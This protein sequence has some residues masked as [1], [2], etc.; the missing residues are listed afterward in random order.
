M[1]EIPEILPIEIPERN[2]MLYLPLSLDKLDE[3]QYIDFFR[4]MFQLENQ[5]LEYHEFAIL[6]IYKLLG[7]KKGKRKIDNNEVDNAL[8]NIARLAEFVEHFFQ[9]EDNRLSLKLSYSQNHI[10]KIRLPFGK[11]L[12][13]PT[14]YFKEV[15]FGQYEDGL[16]RFL[17]YNETPSIELLAELAATFYIDRK[18]KLDFNERKRKLASADVGILFGFYYTFAA[19]HTYFSGSSVYYN[20]KIIDLSIL[21]KDPNPGE[22]DTS[23]YPSLGIKSTAIEIAKTGVLGSLNEVRE[24]PLW[25]V[26]LLLYDMRKKDLDERA[27][28]E[29]QK[30]K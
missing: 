14:D 30:K 10:K 5:K 9:R 24:T 6:V 1:S 13:G 12:A 22:I 29:K 15:S 27:R 18:K 11:T 17:Q 8:S 25:E 19:F 23:P 4:L 28:M 20:G 3:Q 26:A 21:F 7:L 2:L 16:N